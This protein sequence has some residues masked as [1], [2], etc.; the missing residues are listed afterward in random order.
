MTQNPDRADL[1]GR[2]VVLV[3]H[4]LL[5]ANSKVEGLAPYMG[6]H[7]LIA[8]LAAPHAKG[9]ALGVY[10]TLQSLGLFAGG[11]L[12]GAL[13]AFAGPQAVWLACALLAVVWLAIASGSR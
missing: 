7:P 4:C 8:R 9:A 10:N 6:V 13:A 2:R 3:S 1:R 5:N 11:A 12:G